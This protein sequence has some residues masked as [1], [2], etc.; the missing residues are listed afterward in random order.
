MREVNASQASSA[1]VT[2]VNFGMASSLVVAILWANMATME[3]ESDPMAVDMLIAVEGLHDST[4]SSSYI[5][6][7]GLPR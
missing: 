6:E 2:L 4:Y 5:L 1:V 7:Q 3:Y